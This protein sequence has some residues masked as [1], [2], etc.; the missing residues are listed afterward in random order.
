MNYITYPEI[1]TYKN[2]RKM[3]FSLKKTYPFLGV[4]IIGKSLCQ[5]DIFSLTIGKSRNP[6]IIAAGFHAQEWLTVLLALRFAEIILYSKINKTPIWGI[7]PAGITRSIMIIPCVNPDGVEIALDGFESAGRYAENC[8]KIASVSGEKW[9]ANAR[10]VDINHNFDA[11][12]NELRRMET[13]SGILGPSPRRYGGYMPESEPET[14]A[15]VYQCRLY[16]PRT[17]IALHSQ[18]EEIFFEYGN[19]K[20]PRNEE[21]AKILSAVS[22]Y[23]LVENSGLASHGG[24]KDWFIE[25]FNKPAFTIEIGKG[26]NP[27][28]ISDF[29]N[30]IKKCVPMLTLASIL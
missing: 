11:G 3:I 13:D 25:Y 30:I 17:A 22:G 2:Q 16:S 15:L 27:L 8:K 7:D 20:L 1:M 14:K 12:W 28:P 21:I 9:N 5:R 26:E 23:E 29:D 4:N 24:F 19:K 6:L 10:G 18:G